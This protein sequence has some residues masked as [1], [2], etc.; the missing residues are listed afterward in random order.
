VSGQLHALAALHQ[1]KSPRHLLVSRRFVGQLNKLWDG[2]GI[3]THRR[4][5]EQTYNTIHSL[6]TW[7]HRLGDRTVL[8]IFIWILNKESVKVWNG[9]NWLRTGT[10]DTVM[11]HRVWLCWTRWATVRS[12]WRLYLLCGWLMLL[13]TYLTHFVATPQRIN[14]HSVACT[15]PP[16]GGAQRINNTHRSATATPFAVTSLRALLLAYNKHENCSFWTEKER[17]DS[18]HLQLRFPRKTLPFIYSYTSQLLKETLKPRFLWTCQWV[19][20]GSQVSHK[21]SRKNGLQICVQAV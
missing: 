21:G 18:C 12:P 17:S 10:S 16:G 15:G 14:R 7:R 6:R 1:G 13:E 9:L 20:G 2:Q 5:E 19:G 8:T 3:K 4:D 11:K